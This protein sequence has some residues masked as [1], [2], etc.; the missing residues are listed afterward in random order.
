MGRQLNYWYS[1]HV[2]ELFLDLDSIKATNRALSVLRVAIQQKKLKVSGVWLFKTKQKE[3]CHL[4]IT[5]SNIMP[6][7]AKTAWELWLG[8]DRLR[9]A[10]VLMRDVRMRQHTSLLVTRQKYHREPDAECSCNAKHKDDKVT[11]K[12]PALTYL[13]DGDRSADYFARTGSRPSD[14]QMWLMWGKIEIETILK[15][16]GNERKKKRL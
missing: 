2:D 16:R 13:L 12:C 9:S 15:W 8:S 1:A 11:R 10:Y 14:N 3:H 4:I 7:E 5:L 6:I